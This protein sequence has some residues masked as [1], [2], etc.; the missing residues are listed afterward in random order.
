MKKLFAV[1]LAVV[2]VLSMGTVA[3][4]DG[5]GSITIG[6]AKVGE[7]YDVYKMLDFAPIDGQ[8]NKGI[9]T[10]AADSDWVDFFA[11]DLAKQFFTTEA[12]TDGKI[13]VSLKTNVEDVNQELASAAIK[14]AKDNGIAAT[15][16]DEAAAEELVF[17]NLALGY[18]AVDTS[19]GTLCALTNTNSDVTAIEKNAKPDITKEVQED[20]DNTW[21]K[22]NDA[23]IGQ[24]VNY[25]SVITVG[26]GV[27]KYVMHDKMDAGLTLKADSIVVEGANDGDY[28]VKTSCDD[29]C[30]FEIAFT[31]AFIARVGQGKTFTVTYSATLN[32]NA[33]VAHDKGAD[34]YEGNKNTVHL[35]YFNET[36]VE[37]A[38]HETVTYTWKMDVFKYT[39]EGDN[40]VAL[41]GAT[42]Q[43]QANGA[44]LTFTRVE[45]AA[46][47]TYRV[48]P[49][50]AVTDIV[51]E[52][53]NGAD[54]QFII[55][56]LDEGD[57]DL[58]ET[59]APDGYNRAKD[60]NVVITS[61]HDDEN[62]AAEYFFNDD[63]PTRIEVEN[64][65]GGL[66]PETGGIGTT[67]FYV[68]GVAL[69]LAAVVVLV[70]KKRMAS[71]S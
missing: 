63:T 1:L 28:T 26:Q 14:Y 29:G 53:E 48:D 62:L 25:K 64:K 4:A 54:G 71:F 5:T 60:I 68:V 43:L 31:D 10:M 40:K 36:T 13:L 27:T 69:M 34:A 2:L 44:P 41:A 56:G 50:G 16:T 51:T 47:P 35:E 20:R 38:K 33:K 6:N 22:V 8:T 46:V 18:Y 45:G 9:Y 65:T 66:F 39:K 58:V 3:F 70:S 19:L 42:F 24:D 59:D 7:Q 52:V 37:S 21:G 49:N 61:D 23:E 57:Y 17:N 55:I 12:T 30:T 15:A 67:I 32:K 11:T